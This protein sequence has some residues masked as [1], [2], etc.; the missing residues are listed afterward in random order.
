MEDDGTEVFDYG[1]VRIRIRRHVMT[2]RGF[3]V[4]MWEH[5]WRAKQRLTRELWRDDN[6]TR[7]PVVI[8]DRTRMPSIACEHHARDRSTCPS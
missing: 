5:E 1:D 2:E 4:V 3:Q 6:K 7:L 8:P